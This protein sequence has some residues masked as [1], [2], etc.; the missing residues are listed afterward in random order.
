MKRQ[1]TNS[2]GILLFILIFILVITIDLLLVYLYFNHVRNFIQFHSKEIKAE[3]G[4]VFFGDYNDYKTDLG[5]DS[6]KRALSAVDLFMNGK[7]KKIICVG[8][9]SGRYWR[10]K[11]HIMKQFLRKN[12][13]PEQ[14]IIYD[15]IS[16]NTITNWYE[17]QKIIR[18]HKISEVVAISAP[19]HIFRIARMA[20]ED[21]L[22]FFTYNYAPEGF[23]DYVRIYKDVHHEWVSQFMSFALKDEVRNR[24]VYIYRTMRHEI[25]QLI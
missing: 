19:L 15:S 12:G 14:N 7:I 1:W 18:Q 10:G 17:A 4:V 23:S 9:Y 24:I 13:I 11:P 21:D 2:K 6:K 3:A 20:G 16:F 22:Q 5:P 8:G 25:E